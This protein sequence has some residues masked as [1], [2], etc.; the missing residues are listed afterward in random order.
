M[1]VVV[2][3]NRGR[4]RALRRDVLSLRPPPGLRVRENPPPYARRAWAL[5]QTHTKCR[6]ITGFQTQ[7]GG[8]LK[9]RA[10]LADVAARSV[11]GSSSRRFATYSPT[12][13][14]Y[15]GSFFRPR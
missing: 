14:T 7:R 11:S 4:L 10:E 15:D 1:A 8:K 13:A 12:T 6:A 5:G 3:S 9:R 2:R